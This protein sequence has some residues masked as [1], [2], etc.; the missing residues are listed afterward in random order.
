MADNGA[1]RWV[2]EVYFDGGGDHEEDG[3]L[4]HCPGNQ[5]PL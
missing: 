1:W 5:A 3:S 2:S 4:R